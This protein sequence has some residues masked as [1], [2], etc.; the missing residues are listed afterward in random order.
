MDVPD[1]SSS[2]A[3]EG[4]AAHYLA[5]NALGYKRPASFWIGETIIIEDEPFVVDDEMADYVQVY[6]DQV[7]R[8]PGELL[9]EEEFDLSEV[10]GVKGQFGTGDAV[11]LDYE[12]KRLYVGDLKYGRGVIVYAKD[13]EQLYSYG[14]GALRQYD[15]LGDWDTIT[16]AIHQPRLH[17]YDEH[18]L[19]RE[20]LEAFINTAQEAAGLAMAL[21]GKASDVIERAK[22]AGD[23]QCQWC[24]IKGNCA[25]LSKWVH[26]QVYDDFTSL[27]SEPAQ[28]KGASGLS[29]AILG[30]LI[31]RADTIAS[32]VSEWR[33]EGL[34]RVQAGIAVPGWKLVEGRAGKRTWSDESAAERIMKGARMKSDEMYTKKLLTLPAAEKALKKKKPKVWTKLVRLV[35]QAVGKPSLAPEDDRRPALEISSTES[36]HDESDMSDLT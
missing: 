34:R 13:N 29:D 8:E 2:F 30:K 35:T 4:S 31:A 14:A 9:I 36:F 27:E 16:V 33:A 1:E 24:P 11:V 17:H 21:I 26:E 6:V 20:E 32:T 5:Q 3:R 10:Y 23:K 15:M 22:T 7:L 12:N 18:T 28:P 25:T 19:T